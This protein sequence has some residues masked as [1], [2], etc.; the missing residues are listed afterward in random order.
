MLNSAAFRLASLIVFVVTGITAMTREPASASVPPGRACSVSAA[1]ILPPI[2]APPAKKEETL[3]LEVTGYTSTKDQT[4]GDPCIIKHRIN[5]CR[6]KRQ[7]HNICASNVLPEGTR[8]RIEG[9]PGECTVMDTMPSDRTRNI[10]W[11]YGQDPKSNPKGP[12]WRKAMAI[13]RQDR[14]VTIISTP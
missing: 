9:I 6:L 12:L 4:D 2:T 8:I 11:Y 3:V 14:K 5:I 13:G 1:P 10:D 7:G